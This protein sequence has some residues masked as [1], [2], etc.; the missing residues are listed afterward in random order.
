MSDLSEEQEVA[1]QFL[2]GIAAV[3]AVPGSGKVRRIGVR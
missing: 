2:D 1:A 3:V